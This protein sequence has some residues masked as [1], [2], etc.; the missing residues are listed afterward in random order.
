MWSTTATD[1]ADVAA[2]AGLSVEDVVA[3]H[4]G[5]VY[6]CDFCGFAPG[7]AY[8]SGL[9]PRLHAA[10]AGDA[11]SVG[12][13][14]LRRDRRALHGGV[15]VGV[16]GRVAPARAHRCDALGPRR[17][18]SGADHS[19][20][21]GAP[22]PSSTDLGMQT[23]GIRESCPDRDRNEDAQIGGRRCC[24]SSVPGWRRRCRI[25]GGRGTA[26][27]AVPGA[28]AVDRGSAD[29]VNRLVGN[30]PDAAV[31]ETAGGL[32]L[33]VIAAVVVADSTTGAVDTL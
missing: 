23:P 6:R 12:A 30:P 28:G 31:L 33:E 27:L 14:R 11:A 5:A 17:R 1:L 20:Y 7:F 9:D 3:L 22:P 29:L 18:S 26:H 15:P 25:A 2:A 4:S 32:V 16:A 19:R 10:A 13:C 21:D 8:L 24:G